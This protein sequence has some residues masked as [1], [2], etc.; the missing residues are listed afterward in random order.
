ESG[1]PAVGP[2]NSYN[3]TV[4]AG[5]FAGFTTLP[6][7]Q[8]E[9][10]GLPITEGSAIKR[11]FGAS[12]E[13]SL[14]FTWNYATNET[15]ID[16][17]AFLYIPE[18]DLFE[19]LADTKS[20]R[21]VS[22]STFATETGF[23]RYQIDIPN[24][25]DYTVVLGVVNVA[26][27]STESAL[28]V[29]D[30]AFVPAYPDPP[31]LTIDSTL[32]APSFMLVD[33]A[34]TVLEEKASIA[35]LRTMEAGSY[36]VRISGDQSG[37]DPW[38][39]EFDLPDSDAPHVNNGRDVINGGGGDDILVGGVGFDR[40][41]GGLGASRYVSG[42]VEA[43]TSASPIPRTSDPNNLL[44]DTTVLD[45]SVSPS[46]IPDSALRNAVARAAGFP[47]V[48]SGGS[49]I[50][51]DELLS[52]ELAEASRLE[53]FPT[54]G[55][56][57][58]D[59]NG[60]EYLTGLRVATFAHHSITDLS[61][62]GFATD[63]FGA[64]VGLRSIEHLVLDDN[65]IV[66]LNPLSELTTL[67]SLSLDHNP[68]TSLAALSTLENLEYLSA[69]FLP[70]ADSTFDLGLHLPELQLLTVRGSSIS[71][72]NSLLKLTKLEFVDLRDNPLDNSAFDVVIPYLQNELGAEVLFTPNA[73]PTWDSQL[74]WH[75]IFPSTTD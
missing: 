64:P 65:Q 40:L 45:R 19:R 24:E 62:F 50:F 63:S 6:L 17:Y 55:G 51:N 67:R 8:F 39:L 13:G 53:T 31:T 33:S 2:S 69:D 38:Q 22:S 74:V 20:N 18:L 52:S 44:A 1:V 70:L 28:I 72:I 71:N 10:P 49:P 73:A 60:V 58:T 43:R 27:T 9:L 34:G 36:F 41:F 54:D 5:F 26:D 56:K 23:K 75:R 3:V 15:E 16:D 35:D 32:L 4:T 30:F 61:P 12:S 37:A 11:V 66:N 59:L 48:D 46:E 21:F 47:L 57:I 42:S 7:E 68:V 29:D 14:E 25:G